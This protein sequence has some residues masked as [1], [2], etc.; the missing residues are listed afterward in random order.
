[1]YK[2]RIV[3]LTR[4][5]IL[6]A[7]FLCPERLVSFRIIVYSETFVQ[8]QFARVSSY[9]ARKTSL[10]LITDKLWYFFLYSYDASFRN[11]GRSGRFN[12]LD[13]VSRNEY[14]PK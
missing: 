13:L 4:E 10:S 5:R 9:C 6:A 3:L 8:S 2:H 1:M 11:K 12:P 14:L 7:Y